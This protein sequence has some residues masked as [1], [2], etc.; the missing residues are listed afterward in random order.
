MLNWPVARPIEKPT[1]LERHVVSSSL[2]RSVGF[3]TVYLCST[4]N[5]KNLLFTNSVYV[6]CKRGNDS[7]SAVQSLLKLLRTVT[8]GS[9]NDKDKEGFVL[10]DIIGGLTA[11]SNQID[12]TF[13]KY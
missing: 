11:W 3:P 5:I 4:I 13:P 10:K 12:H 8:D 2:A 7:Q 6:V 9:P 1:D